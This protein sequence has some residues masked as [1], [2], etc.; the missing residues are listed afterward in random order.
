MKTKFLDLF[1]LITNKMK[2]TSKIIT[3]KTKIIFFFVGISSLIW[4]LIRVIPKPSRA[5]YPCMKVA[6]PIMSGFVIYL[7]TLGGSVLAF[8]KAF[9]RFFNFKYKAAVIFLVLAIVASIAFFVTDVRTMFASTNLATLEAPNTPIGEAKGI[10]PGR[11]VWVMDKA[12]TNENCT[13]K[14]GDYWFMSKNTDQAVLEKM[15]ANGL[16]SVS[17]QKTSAAA[18]DTIFKYFNS[19]HNKGSVGYTSGEKIVIKVNC[20]TLGNGG[21]NL[22]DALDASPQLALALLEQLIDTLKITQ[23][24]ITFG[25]PYRGMPDE[26]YIPCHTKYPSVHYIEG[27]GTDGREQ[28]KISTSNVFFTSDNKFQSRLPQ[29]YLDAAYLINMPSLKTHNSAGVTIA[30]KNHQGSVIVAGQD[31]TS[32][33]MGDNLHYDYVDQGAKNQVMGIYRHITDYIAHKKLGGNTLI[34]IVDAIW[35]GRNWDGTIEKWQMPPFNNDWTSSLFLSQDPVATESV[36]FDF[37]YN[38]YK[39][40]PNAHGK[41]DYPLIAGVQDYIHQA[42]DPKSWATGIKYDPSSS[43]HSS[44]VGSLGVHEHW[45]SITAKQYSRNLGL[46]T[47][48]EL[49]GVPSSLVITSIKG[50]SIDN[51][52]S[53]SIFPNPINNVATLKYTLSSSANVHIELYSLDGKQV[54][55]TENLRQYS[56]VNTFSL[57]VTN[58]KLS[59]GTYVC[60]VIASG[61]DLNTFTSKILIR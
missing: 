27:L 39:N 3:T 14:A 43:D 44:P 4:F 19:N 17:G 52:N 46:N 15:L 22:N 28:T 35:S 45:N 20:T 42:A 54:I 26:I 38:E 36:G 33:Y 6:A 37:L 31:A 56:G 2:L 32:Q 51:S 61:S 50:N 13:N 34:Y 47:G 58:Y 1:N 12:V 16:M 29:A 30:A 10:F 7:I 53:L 11:V 18:W 49:F 21:R 40:Y 48:I 57:N 25:D 24:N 5:L 59:S 9:E 8:R 23:A 41:V 60:K 55:N